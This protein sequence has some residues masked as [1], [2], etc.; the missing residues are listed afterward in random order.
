M[1]ETNENADE[2]LLD[3]PDRRF[4]PLKLHKLPDEDV[5]AIVPDNIEQLTQVQRTGK[6]GRPKSPA[7]PFD[8]V[9]IDEQNHITVIQKN[10]RPTKE[11]RLLREGKVAEETLMNIARTFYYNPNWQT[12]AMLTGHTADFLLTF[13]KTLKFHD[14]LSQIRNELDATEQADESKI[15]EQALTEIQD[16]LKHG[17]DILDSKTGTII[18]V[19]PKAKEL[20]SIL[21]TVHNVRQITRGEATSRTESISPQDKLSKIAENFAKFAAAK[22][23]TGETL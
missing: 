2:V 18:K 5:A 19:K 15:V 12:V 8:V 14:L 11:L 3:I 1:L 10:G 16:R 17:D 21:K 9:E 23:I 22:D 6:K 20:A 4:D 13:S 7:K